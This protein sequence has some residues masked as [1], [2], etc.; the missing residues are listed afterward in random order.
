MTSIIPT[1]QA[2]PAAI[3]TP[4]PAALH[5]LALDIANLLWEIQQDDNAHAQP[6]IAELT[7]LMEMEG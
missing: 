1:M 3:G 2:Q 7:P 4:P 5:A 6:F